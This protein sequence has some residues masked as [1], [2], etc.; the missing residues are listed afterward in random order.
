MIHSVYEWI[1]ANITEVTGTVL[2]LVYIVF[3]IRQNILTWP[4]GLLSS[5]FY[6]IIFFSSQLYA[7]MGLQVYYAFIS[8]YGW[9]YWK[10]SQ[11]EEVTN[12]IAFVKQ[13]RK[14]LWIRIL[15][16]EIALFILLYFLLKHLTDSDVP[17]LDALTT[18]TSI[19]ATWMLARK[20]LENWIVWIFT[21]FICIFLYFQKGLWPTTILFAVYTIMAFVGYFEWRK[22]L[23]IQIEKN[24]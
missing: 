17:V 12:Q 20:L 1:T 13:T 19:I 23:N 6:I 15:V 21:D 24:T 16:A 4:I 22:N 9:Y 11:K 5:V 10:K 14:S 8:I 7:A 18:S 2:G 3:S